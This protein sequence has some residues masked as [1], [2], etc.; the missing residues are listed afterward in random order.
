MSG[1]CANKQGCCQFYH[2]EEVKKA[3][4]YCPCIGN[5]KCKWK[6]L[7]KIIMNARVQWKRVHT[8]AIRRH[9]HSTCPMPAPSITFD[10]FVIVNGF[11]F[12]CLLA[13]SVI[14]FG[15]KWEEFFFSKKK[16]EIANLMWILWSICALTLQT[17]LQIH[18]IIIYLSNKAQPQMIQSYSTAK[19]MLSSIKDLVL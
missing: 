15:M 3:Q 4:R 5:E 13:L 17:K 11:L 18:T 9:E 12:T 6:K 14:V 8:I 2:Y 7:Q 19:I 16:S 10:G 1:I